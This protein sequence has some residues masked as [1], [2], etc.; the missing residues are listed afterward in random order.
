MGVACVLQ[1]RDDVGM[2]YGDIGGW[3]GGRWFR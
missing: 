1:R 3:V 2:D